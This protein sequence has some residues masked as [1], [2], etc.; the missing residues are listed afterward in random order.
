MIPMTSRFARLACIALALGPAT[1][2]A[3][4]T[5]TLRCRA[6]H[7][8]VDQTICASPEYVAMDREIAALTD[9][10]KAQMPKGEQSQLAE[11]TARYM[12]QRKGCGW[13]AHNSAHP[14]TAIDECV[15]ASME[16]RV[17]RLRDVVDRSSL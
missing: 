10:A 16:T 7:G 5:A 15:R 4:A 2:L 17:R 6:A 9:R 3:A 14:G 12:R 13:A 1:D 8:M 11:S